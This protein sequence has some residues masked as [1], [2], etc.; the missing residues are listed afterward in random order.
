MLDDV[1]VIV[2]EGFWAHG[3]E[4]KKKITVLCNS[5]I[6]MVKHS[7]IF[8]ILLNIFYFSLISCLTF[9]SLIK[10]VLACY[11]KAYLPISYSK[12]EQSFGSVSN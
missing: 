11:T 12:F 3:M 1:V 9:F 5:E 4:E 6:W 7:Q 10:Y 2:I 8:G